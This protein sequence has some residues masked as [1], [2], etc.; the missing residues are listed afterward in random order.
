MTGQRC[1]LQAAVRGF[2]MRRRAWLP[3]AAAGVDYDAAYWQRHTT[4]S[5][6]P[7]CGRCGCNPA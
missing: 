2:H 3:H 7:R 1:A 6:D 4:F 5:H